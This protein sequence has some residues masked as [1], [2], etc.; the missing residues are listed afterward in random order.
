MPRRLRVH[1]PGGFYHVTLRGNH[2]QNIFAAENDRSLLNLIVARAIEKFGTRVH[3]YCWMST[4]P[5]FLMQVSD[6]PLSSPMRQIGAEFARA[7]QVKLETTGHYFERRYHATLVDADSYLLELVRY[8]HLNP[9]RAGLV[10]D[11]AGHRWSSHHAYLGTRVESWVTTD[12]ALRMFGG[13]RARAVAAYQRFLN[14]EPQQPWTPASEGGIQPL[15]VGSPEFVARVRRTSV[16]MSVRG[17]LSDLI[18]EVCRR[19]EVDPEKLDSPLRDTYLTKVRP[20]IAHQAKVRHIATLSAVARILGR[21]EATLR[22]AIRTYP[23]EI[24]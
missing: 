17:T 16:P 2:Q 3:A 14:C 13:E 4:H 12:F 24:E 15:V 6:E 23:E 11:P 21:D 22:E 5:H 10:S 19:F 20:W 8:I 1:L 9:V 18:A 7:M